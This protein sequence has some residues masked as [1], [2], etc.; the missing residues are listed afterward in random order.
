MGAPKRN[1]T[2]RSDATSGDTT[3]CG[4]AQTAMEPTRLTAIQHQRVSVNDATVITPMPKKPLRL[5]APAPSPK[6]PASGSAH[7]PTRTVCLHGP[8]VTAEGQVVAMPRIGDLFLGFKIVD[9][10]GEGGF[11]SVFLA[12]QLGLAARPVALKFTSRPNHEP[13][14]LATRPLRAA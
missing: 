11:G 12:E 9:K 1:V 8:N 2:R 10:L 6:P 4:A 7:E 13:E 5:E 3:A 14:R